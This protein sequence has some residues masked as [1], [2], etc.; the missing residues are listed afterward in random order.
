MG[1]LSMNIRPSPKRPRVRGA[2][3]KFVSF[4]NIHGMGLRVFFLKIFFVD[5]EKVHIAQ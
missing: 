5:K 3:H 1:C 2:K 4:I